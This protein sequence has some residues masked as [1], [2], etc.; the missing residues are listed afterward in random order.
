MSVITIKSFEVVM[1]NKRAFINMIKL[2]DAPGKIT[3]QLNRNEQF[4]CF[5]TSTE[6]CLL[7]NMIL[8][9]S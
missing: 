2:Q 5:G 1:L 3:N 7:Q 8:S 4:V 6:T 9:L